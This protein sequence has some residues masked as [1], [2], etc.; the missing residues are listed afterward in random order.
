MNMI[1]PIPA[2]E[3]PKPDLLETLIPLFLRSLSA[4]LCRFCTGFQV[5]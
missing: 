5:C 1:L 4:L 2:A 3:V